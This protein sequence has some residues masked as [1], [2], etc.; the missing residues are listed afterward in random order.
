MKGERYDLRVKTGGDL[1]EDGGDTRYK[2]K[3]EAIQ[4]MNE[5]TA[6]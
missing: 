4:E 6:L 5:K 2:R 3:I 1:K